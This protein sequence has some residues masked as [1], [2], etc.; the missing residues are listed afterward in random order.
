LLTWCAEQRDETPASAGAIVA[1]LR[2][3]QQRHGKPYGTGLAGRAGSGCWRTLP[4][5]QQENLQSEGD[6]QWFID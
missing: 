1:G 2:H 4:E 5:E 6:K 3:Q